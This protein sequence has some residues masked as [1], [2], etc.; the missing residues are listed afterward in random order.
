MRGRSLPRFVS[1]R[2]QSRRRARKQRQIEEKGSEE[3]QEATTAAGD[4]G[5]GGQADGARVLKRPILP[6]ALTEQFLSVF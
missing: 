5:T 1:F 2:G 4:D 6:L 3:Q